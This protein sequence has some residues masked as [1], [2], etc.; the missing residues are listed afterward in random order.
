MTSI[1]LQIQFDLLISL[2][3]YQFSNPFT[4]I[5]FII[6]LY[7]VIYEKETFYMILHDISKILL[8]YK[9]NILQLFCFI[10]RTK[11][12]ETTNCTKGVLFIWKYLL[13]NSSMNELVFWRQGWDNVRKEAVDKHTM[14]IHLW[15]R[16]LIE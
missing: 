14:H 7:I 11:N 12:D 13:T 6:Q 2:C 1:Y 10:I 5:I 3:K 4:P 15:N 16:K 9:W 8:W